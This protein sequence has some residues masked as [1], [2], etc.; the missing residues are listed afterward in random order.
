MEQQ[1]LGIT[2]RLWSKLWHNF[3]VEAAA[4]GITKWLWIGKHYR[5]NQVVM[6]L[7]A[8]GITRVVME[9]QAGITK[10]LWSE[11]W[12]NLQLQQQSLGITKW[13]WS[14]KQFDLT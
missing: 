10:W 2:K 3:A 5:Y 12:H 9:Q 11:F 8:L 13:L 6:K 14:S 7:Q 1:A 4:L